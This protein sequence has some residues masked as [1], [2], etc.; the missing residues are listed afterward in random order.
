MPLTLG[1]KSYCN[2]EHP[3]PFGGNVYVENFTCISNEVM[4]FGNSAHYG[5]L[6]RNCV[7]NHVFVQPTIEK[8]NDDIHIGSDVWIGWGAILIPK[9]GQGLT[10]GHGAIIGA[11]CIVTKDVPPYA[12]V[13]GNPSK[14][15]KYRFDPDTISKL[16]EIK[17]WNWPEY[18]IADRREEFRDV[19]AFVNKY[20]QKVNTEKS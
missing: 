14:V 1:S 9:L 20:Y 4:F 3:I 6:N 8:T 12:V 17:W 5:L 13:V 15:A 19:H 18:L 7:T 10:I 2:N 16:L 11:S